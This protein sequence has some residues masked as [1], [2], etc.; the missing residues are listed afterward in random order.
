MALSVLV[1]GGLV[2]VKEGLSMYLAYNPNATGTP[3]KRGALMFNACNSSIF[4]SV[5]P[6]CAKLSHNLS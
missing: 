5:A 4:L 3:K 2:F 6:Y 1:F